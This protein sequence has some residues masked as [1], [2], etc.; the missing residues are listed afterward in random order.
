M[1]HSKLAI[2]LHCLAFLFALAFGVALI[3][4]GAG[5]LEES[6]VTAAFTDTGWMILLIAL[7]AALLAIAL[8][9]LLVL[10]ED[11]LNGVLFS[12]TGEW[13]RVEVAPMAVRELISGILRRDMGLERFR[14]FLERREDAVA[15]RVRTALTS[16]QRVSEVGERIQRELARHV[17]ERTG[18]EVREVTVFVR[19][20]RARQDAVREGGGDEPAA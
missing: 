6:T 16:D 1:S 15:I 8:H 13:G 4:T 17:A 14:V 3:L 18:V 19:S 12:R 9:F 5:V 11:R 20:M 2:V 10:A 7:G